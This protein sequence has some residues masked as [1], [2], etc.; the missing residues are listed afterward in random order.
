MKDDKSVVARNWAFRFRCI[1][2]EL[3]FG[4]YWENMAVGTA[5]IRDSTCILYTLAI[6]FAIPF[7]Q[8]RAM[9]TT[10]R[11]ISPDQEA[12]GFKR[13][14]SAFENG[15]V[16]FSAHSTTGLPKQSEDTPECPAPRSQ[17]QWPYP[18]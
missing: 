13:L 16:S 17:L 18:D 8:F 9:R 5:T 1:P 11:R 12:A 14:L 7:L 15:D 6:V 3:V 10:A 2:S 4:V